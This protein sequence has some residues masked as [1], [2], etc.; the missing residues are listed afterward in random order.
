[1]R[2][3]VEVGPSPK[4]TRA[5][6][7]PRVATSAL[8]ERRGRRRIRRATAPTRS[9]GPLPFP[10]FT[11]VH[12]LPYHGLMHAREQA[13]KAASSKS[14]PAPARPTGAD[15]Q[16]RILDLQRTLGNA[17]VAEMLEEVQRSSVHEVLRSAGRPLD[18]P[19]RQEM[20]SR[21]SADFSEVRVHTDTAAQRSAAEIGARAYTSGDHVVIG[22]GGADKHTLA[23]ELTH[24]LQ[25]R[26]G[27]VAG[28]DNGQGL[29]ISDRADRFEREAEANAARAMAAPDPALADLQRAPAD[30]PAA[31]SETF[32]QRVAE[33]RTGPTTLDAEDDNY[34][35]DADDF[36]ENI[37]PK[38]PA[39]TPQETVRQLWSSGSDDIVTLWRGTT[40]A[41]ANAMAAAGSAGGITADDNTPRPGQAQAQA[42]IGAGGQLAEFTADSG[43]AEGFSFRSALVVVRVK[44][45][46]LGKGSE[47]ESGWILLGSAPVEVVAV[48]DRTRGQQAGTYANAS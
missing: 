32:V 14:Q 40:L 39:P 1:M 46:Y 3:V 20:E 2:R 23:H 45:S 38:L 10:A 27:A 42:Q 12:G 13:G 43:V 26:Q 34:D 29:R 31:A 9:A 37:S 25:Q 7:S 5:C 6:G 24:V 22:S 21:L 41:K 16:S 17:A 33:Y 47:T 4:A 8:T 19:V 28:T 30:G 15:Q 48:V 18:T 44:A 35:S 36:D 11:L